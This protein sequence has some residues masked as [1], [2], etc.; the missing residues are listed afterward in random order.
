MGGGGFWVHHWIRISVLFNKV[1]D[2][3]YPS[4]AI[5]LFVKICCSLF[6]LIS[7]YLK[8]EHSFVWL[9]PIPNTQWSLLKNDFFENQLCFRIWFQFEAFSIIVATNCSRTAVW[10]GN[11]TKT[12]QYL[13][14]FL[15]IFSFVISF[16][17]IPKVAEVLNQLSLSGTE[18]PY[19]K[20][21]NC[22]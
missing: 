9:V 7:F 4:V 5:I 14:M 6:K 16:I 17:S 18:S 13:R 11:K 10:G 2:K 3:S 22:V 20:Q 21:K 19:S 12:L 8:E 15:F 1:R